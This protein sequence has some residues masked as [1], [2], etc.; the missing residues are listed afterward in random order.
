MPLSDHILE[1]MVDAVIAVDSAVAI[2][3]INGGAERLLGY[4]GGELRG[5]PLSV[6]LFEQADLARTTRVQAVSAGGE[7]RK[8]EVMLRA[9][10]GSA[11]PVSITGSPILDAGGDFEGIVFVARDLRETHRLIA[12]LARARASVQEQLDEARRQLLQAER[13]STLGTLAAGVGHELRNL[14]QLYTGCL[15]QLGAIDGPLRDDLDWVGQHLE[16][17]AT[18]LLDL[19]RP[20]RASSEP[21]ALGEIAA[22]VLEMLRVAGK[23]KTVEIE[24]H[25]AEH[26]PVIAVRTRLEQVLLNLI[27]NAIDALDEPGVKARRVSVSVFERDGRVA[28]EIA[29]SGCGIAPANLAKIFDA[30]FTTKAPGRG[31][32]LGLPVVKQILDGLGGDLAVESSEAGTTMRFTL[33]AA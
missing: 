24:A 26:R 29:D 30:F 31:T 11:I 12:E 6:L 28:C 2:S 9:R 13:L 14:S 21:V 20:A 10:D 32:G 15:D 17:Y 4:S 27:K 23:T 8:E 7:L 18:H 16:S 19:A 5:S 1:A 33:P 3:A 25:Y 22:G